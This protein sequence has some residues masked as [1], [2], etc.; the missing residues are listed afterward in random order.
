MPTVQGV[1]KI[2]GQFWA[3]GPTVSGGGFPSMRT[4]LDGIN[5]TVADL[6]SNPNRP[7]S[8]N[9]VSDI[10]GNYGACLTPS[11]NYAYVLWASSKT[12]LSGMSYPPPSHGGG[13]DTAYAYGLSLSRFN[14]STKRWDY[15]AATGATHT[16]LNLS[17]GVHWPVFPKVAGDGRECIGGFAR[18]FM[19]ATDD[20]T[21]HA[22]MGYNIRGVL[23]ID[24]STVDHYE[25]QA[26]YWNNVSGVGSATTL[27]RPS[28]GTATNMGSTYIDGIFGVKAATD[29][30]MYYQPGI[31]DG[32]A[33]DSLGNVYCFTSSPLL[34][35]FLIWGKKIV[36]GVVTYAGDG[37]SANGPSPNDPYLNF[38]IP[39][40]TSPTFMYRDCSIVAG[41]DTGTFGI[42]D[43]GF[44][45]NNGIGTPILQTATSGSPEY[46]PFRYNA[47]FG[48]PPSC[49]SSPSA[50][51]AMP[52][53]TSGRYAAV[54]IISGGSYSR[55]YVGD[56]TNQV[57]VG[58][59]DDF[60][61][62]FLIASSIGMQDYTMNLAVDPVTGLL[63]LFW[64]GVNDPYLSSVAVIWRSQRL[65]PGNWT[66]PR[67]FATLTQTLYSFSSYRPPLKA[68]LF[69]LFLDPNPPYGWIVSFQGPFLLNT[70]AAVGSWLF[71]ASPKNTSGLD[72][73]LGLT[74]SLGSGTGN[75]SV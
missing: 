64:F 46:S 67:I 71:F 32:I 63:N 62:S 61:G 21:V 65:G 10:I 3:F 55:E 51:C 29:G 14:F 45:Y 13:G 20:N 12:V 26:G 16:V 1:W 68:S 50:G 60:V 6:T 70:G 34:V 52:V 42:V 8:D 5:W 24:G 75:Y 74:Q 69:A 30:T 37:P 54:D 23:W 19:T 39:S 73:G 27:L 35:Y 66:P 58:S 41:P 36:G 17:G 25:E 9:S 7:R 47:C 22:L 4:S 2:N 49:F 57:A 31:P 48:G 72:I 28:M 53:K 40:G 15:T 43:D 11:R 33:S 38:G 59:M 44:A 56:A 18:I